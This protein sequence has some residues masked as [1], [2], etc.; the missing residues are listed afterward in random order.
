MLFIILSFL[1]FR[2]AD[3]V[4]VSFA[5]KIIPCLGRFAYIE[6]VRD[7]NLPRLISSLANFDGVYYI[8]IAIQG[9][10]QYE[11]AFFPLY[12][13]LIKILSPI[14]ANNHLL[15]GL[16]I[17][18][19]SF[20]LGLIVFI[21]YLKTRGVDDEG[22]TR[23]RVSHS[24][25]NPPPIKSGDSQVVRNR[26]LRF[27]FWPVL[28]LVLF[29]TSFFFGA[30]YTEGLFFF[31][32]VSSLYFAKKEKYFLAGI[33]AFLAS[34][35]RLLGVFLIIPFLFTLWPKR[36]RVLG[37][38]GPKVFLLLFPLLGFLTYS[39]YLFKTTGDPF[40]FFSSLS[41][42]G[43]QRSTHLVLLPQVYF[44]YFKIFLTAGHNFQYFI[45]LF[46]FIVFN[47]VFFIVILNLLASLRSGLASL[48]SGFQ[49]LHLKQ[50]L[51]RVQHDKKPLNYDRI[52][53]GL[54]SLINLLL[55]TATGSFSSIPRYVL[56]SFSFFIF[57]GEM[58]NNYIKIFLAVLFFVFHIII[59]GFFTQGY[60]VS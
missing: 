34:L 47:L 29:P 6:V 15:A 54:F 16:V 35:T 26:Y 48:R 45:S 7:S 36:S 42:F 2:A 49:D 59:L 27:S 25:G 51:N 24:G 53:L 4:I 19:V 40:S 13:M 22:K 1:I 28:L 46:E 57:I 12:P 5:T 52:G 55:P 44:R 17:S 33:F 31:L 38:Y 41:A 21:K 58:K 3:L 9:Y 32:A 60:F 14:F 20:L 10:S 50:M 18:N 56:L 43:T 11:Q 39:L 30:V 23:Y 8:R 37:S